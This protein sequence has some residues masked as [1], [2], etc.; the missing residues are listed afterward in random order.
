M[1]R[2]IQRDPSEEEEK[3][4][5]DRWQKKWQ[6]GDGVVAGDNSGVVV[7]GSVEDN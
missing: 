4:K 6:D 5:E 7:C 2:N 1:Q 3:E